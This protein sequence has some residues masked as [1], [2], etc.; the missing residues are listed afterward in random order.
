MKKVLAW[1]QKVVRMIVAVGR[2]LIS[3]NR[4]STCKRCGEDLGGDGGDA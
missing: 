3:V 1:E 4:N 2:M